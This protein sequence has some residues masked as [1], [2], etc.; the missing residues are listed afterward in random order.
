MAATPRPDAGAV[1]DESSTLE[2]STSW[3]AP[4]AC[5]VVLH[6]EVDVTW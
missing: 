3:Y 2:K 4:I 5:G 1:F 6:S